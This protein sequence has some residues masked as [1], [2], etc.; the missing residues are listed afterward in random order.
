ML[1]CIQ[2]PVLKKI[3]CSCYRKPSFSLNG[4]V[5]SIRIAIHGSKINLFLACI[6]SLHTGL[7]ESRYRE[8]HCRLVEGKNSLHDQIRDHTT[9]ERPFRCVFSNSLIL[10]AILCITRVNQTVSMLCV[11]QVCLGR[12]SGFKVTQKRNSCFS[13]KSIVVIAQKLWGESLG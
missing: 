1:I 2:R 3:N 4:G 8:L 5:V 7:N 10:P 12:E 9:I 11:M 13:L 6:Y